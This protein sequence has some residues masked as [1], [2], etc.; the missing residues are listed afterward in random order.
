M[1]EWFHLL[2]RAFQ[3]TARGSEEELCT[4][5]RSA[6]ERTELFHIFTLIIS[7]AGSAV[8]GMRSR[9]TATGGTLWAH[10]C[11]FQ[12]VLLQLTRPQRQ[13]TIRCPSVLQEEGTRSDAVT[14]HETHGETFIVRLSN[15]S[16]K[17][18]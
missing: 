10:T 9:R 5:V 16:P 3:E 15:G 6:G 13:V 18:T 8:G 17:K 2:H 4:E 14:R 11:F 1:T 7:P 12:I